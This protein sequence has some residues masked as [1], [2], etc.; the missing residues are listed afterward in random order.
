M[1]FRINWL[2]WDAAVKAV[3]A[4]RALQPKLNADLKADVINWQQYRAAG[5]ASCD[6]ALADEL[7][8]LYSIR[9]MGRGRVH[10]SGARLTRSQACGVGLKEL[11]NG[12]YVVFG[13]TI[14][15]DMTA[16][17]Q[18]KYVGDAWKEYERQ[19]EPAMVITEM[20]P[21]TTS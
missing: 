11:N 9:A 13:G 14:I 15:H 5:G 1:R 10:R 18:E 17:H 16:E 19:P 20:V 3:E 12:Q 6:E 2:K 21:A 8:K 4:R 7:T